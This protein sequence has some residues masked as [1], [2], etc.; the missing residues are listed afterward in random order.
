MYPRL[1]HFGHITLPTGGVL[2]AFALLAFLLAASA[3]AE[4]LRGAAF[5]EHVWTAGAVGILTGLVSA[6]MLV[7]AFHLKDFIAHPFWMLGLTNLDDRYVY[8]GV[9]LGICASGGYILAHRL[10]VPAVLDALAP[11]ASLGLAIASLGSLAAGSGFG[12]PT[13]ARWG[14]VYTSRL[15]TRWSGTPLGVPLIP[16]QLYA[17]LA[18]AAIGALILWAV[19]HAPRAGDAAGLW[20][21]A[22]GLG[23]F[24]LEQL[25]YIPGTEWLVLGALTLPQCFA[26]VAVMVAGMIWLRATSPAP[27]SA[28]S[29]PAAD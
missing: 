10:E 11:A 18:H 1:V 2:A 7:I 14:V 17:A 25:R 16:V 12:L 9:V 13:S 6:R 22:T 27:Q 8:S 19:L 3:L 26:T 24:L 28:P 23:V 5:S 4:R 29:L 21:F 20:L 15:A